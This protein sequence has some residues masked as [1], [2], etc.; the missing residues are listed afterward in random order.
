MREGKQ[1]SL[2]LRDTK[3]DNLL[4]RFGIFYAR[5]AIGGAFLSAVADRFGLWGPYG[6]HNVSWGSFHNFTGYVA[7]VNSFL[8]ASWA[9]ALA[10]MATAAEFS[11]GIA[12]I[13]GLWPRRVCLASATL[14]AMFGIAMAISFGIES[15]LSYSV[16]SASAGALV[17]GLYSGARHN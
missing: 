11:L 4:G 9:P 1:S 14:L 5:L 3:R 6:K 17:L 13:I 10:W 7:K 15:P 16:F 8:P 12:L 2:P